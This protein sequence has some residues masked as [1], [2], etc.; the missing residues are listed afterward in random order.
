MNLIN[1]NGRN[2]TKFCGQHV[3][4]IINE[5]YLMVEV[6]T[7][8][9]GVCNFMKMSKYTIEI[10]LYNCQLCNYTQKTLIYRIKYVN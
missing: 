5:A 2:E 4:H 3:S 1:K 10:T 7:C 9:F 6:C 8:L